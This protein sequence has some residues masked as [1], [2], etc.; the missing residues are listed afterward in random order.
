MSPKPAFS[1]LP[2]TTSPRWPRLTSDL[3]TV[4]KVGP[5]IR[6]F[7]L[8]WAWRRLPCPSRGSHPSQGAIEPRRQTTSLGRVEDE[9][10]PLKISIFRAARR[11]LQV[12]NGETRKKRGWLY[13]ILAASKMTWVVLMTLVTP[14]K[15]HMGCLTHV[16]ASDLPVLQLIHKRWSQLSKPVHFLTRWEEA[17]RGVD[18]ET[19]ASC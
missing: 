17:P 1:P 2:P 6:C 5:T 15:W 18:T 14:E 12:Q 16:L 19:Q 11:N 7:S 3:S 10:W 13:G 8:L 4:H 9:D